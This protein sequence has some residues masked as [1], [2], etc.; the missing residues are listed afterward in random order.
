[1][2]KLQLKLSCTGEHYGLL[3]HEYKDLTSRLNKLAKGQLWEVLLGKRKE[4]VNSE[5]ELNML[6]ELGI[7]LP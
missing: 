7:D 5:P 4:C 1:M 3:Q 6:A 2:L